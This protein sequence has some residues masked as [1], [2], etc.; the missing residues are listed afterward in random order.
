[1]TDS[2]NKNPPKSDLEKLSRLY[3]TGNLANVESFCGVLL[4]AYP[5]SPLVYN[6]LGVALEAVSYTHLTLPTKCRV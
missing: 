4:A 2:E 5:D 6:V 3:R 1:M